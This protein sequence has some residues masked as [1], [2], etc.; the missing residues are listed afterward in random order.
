MGIIVEIILIIVT[1]Y[2]LFWAFVALAAIISATWKIILSILLVIG[3]IAAIYLAVANRKNNKKFIILGIALMVCCTVGIIAL[4]K[5]TAQP[6]IS[7]H[8]S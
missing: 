1:L 4:N 6:Q 7:V 2:W 5:K 3:G 8:G